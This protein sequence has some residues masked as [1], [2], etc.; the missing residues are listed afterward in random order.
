MRSSKGKVPLADEK[1]VKLLMTFGR[2]K[3][4]L[5]LEIKKLADHLGLF[6]RIDGF[7]FDPSKQKV[8]RRKRR[9]Q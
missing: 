2:R 6:K 3:K 9:K 4:A 5:D 8:T 7:C 1:L